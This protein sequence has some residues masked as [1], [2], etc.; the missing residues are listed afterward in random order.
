MRIPLVH[1]VL[2]N[3]Q[4]QYIGNSGF[5]GH[6]FGL[7]RTVYRV[8]EALFSGNEGHPFG[9]RR[10]VYRVMRDGTAYKSITIKGLWPT[11][12]YYRVY[13]GFIGYI[14]LHV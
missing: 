1:T 13:K 11:Y 3:H 14:G 6:P 9:L 5:E 12:R 4:Q 10:T 7:R 8:M 2:A